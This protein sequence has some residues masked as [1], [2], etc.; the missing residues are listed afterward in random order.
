MVHAGFPV[1][2]SGSKRKTGTER[3]RGDVAGLMN[4]SGLSSM[5]V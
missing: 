3:M 2:V 1:L 5:R 4:T